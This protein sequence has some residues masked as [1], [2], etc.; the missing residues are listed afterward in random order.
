MKVYLSLLFGTLS[1]TFSRIALIVFVVSAIVSALANIIDLDNSKYDSIV[2]FV[3]IFPV[4]I[5]ISILF[6]SG[7]KVWREELSKVDHVLNVAVIPK[8]IFRLSNCNSIYP[9]SKGIL[10][11]EINLSSE[12]G[13][14]VTLSDIYLENIDPLL[15]FFSNN[16]S[17]RLFDCQNSSNKFKL[18]KLIKS[19]SSEYFSIEF[20]FQPLELEIDK[21]INNVEP[22]HIMDYAPLLNDAKDFD[23]KLIVEYLHL[24]QKYTETMACTVELSQLKPHFKKKWTEKRWIHAVNL[25]NA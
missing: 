8:P 12:S 2:N 23:I 5:L 22:K 4:P 10:S 3:S 7:Y 21:P 15:I 24:G 9:D 19:G 18:P 1:D 14:D 20:F 16:Y 6:Y 13:S 25:I 17:S 11:F